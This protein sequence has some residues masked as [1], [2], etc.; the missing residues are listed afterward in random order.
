MELG[1]AHG[2]A[3]LVVKVVFGAIHAIEGQ[4]ERL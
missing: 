2:L 3:Q 1:L 4:S